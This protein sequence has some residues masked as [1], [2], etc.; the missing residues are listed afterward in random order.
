MPLPHSTTH[1]RLRQVGEQSLP[2]ICCSIQDSG[3]YAM[4]GNPVKLALKVWVW[5]I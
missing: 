4:P 3:P 2:I 1:Q 5:E